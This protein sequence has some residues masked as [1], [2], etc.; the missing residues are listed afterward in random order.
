MRTT[1]IL[2]N[3]AA[4]QHN[5]QR[6]STLAPHAKIMAMVKANAYGHGV[7]M[8]LPALDQAD[9][10]GVATLA[11]AMEARNL[12]WLKP[13]TIVEG[14]FSQ[15]EWQTAIDNNLQCVIHHQNQLD[16]ALANP[17]PTDTL[18]HTIW[19]KYNTGM[20]RLG[21]TTD[22]VATVA[23]QLTQAGYHIVL[24]SHFA[25]ADDKHTPLNATQCQLFTT[26]L[27]QL[28]NDISPSIQGSLCNSA[29]LVNFPECHFDWVR[30]GIM[31]YGSSPVVDQSA[32]ELQLQSVMTLQSKIMAIHQL[33]KGDMVGYGSRWTAQQPSTI[34]IVS[35][36]YGDGYPRVVQDDAWVSVH[37]DNNTSINTSIKAPIIGRVAMDMIVIDLTDTINTTDAIDVD[38][39]TSLIDKTVTL[40]G[41]PTNTHPQYTPHIDEVANYA[42]TIG[43]ELLCRLTN[44]PT[45]IYMNKTQSTETT[46][47]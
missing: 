41:N 37:L 17:A 33:N 15:E 34:A 10:I 25:N 4:L 28:K 30:P 20:N 6:V 23:K 7:D 39:P 8:C 11:E 31:L 40:W 29:G 2:I 12:G 19:L 3:Q 27:T 46:Q 32:T 24:I 21:F 38:T 43:Y 36:G 13:I 47:H 5:L 42:G 9:A 35:I 16:W 45:R 18:T 14:V 22:E 44:R 26:M 1:N